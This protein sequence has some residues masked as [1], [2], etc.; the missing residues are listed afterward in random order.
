[1]IFPAA[2]ASQLSESQAAAWFV[3]LTFTGLIAILDFGISTL[4][5]KKISQESNT[6]DKKRFFNYL[7]L[8]TIMLGLI[9]FLLIMVNES[10]IFNLYSISQSNQTSHAFLLFSG[11]AVLFLSM[12][13]IEAYI[14]ALKFG[15]IISR[16]EIITAILR[17]L[18]LSYVWYEHEI[19]ILTL[20]LCYLAPCILTWIYLL[21]LYQRHRS[22]VDTTL[23]NKDYSLISDVTFSFNSWLITVVA[24]FNRQG[25]FLVAAMFVTTTDQI[26]LALVMLI[27][28]VAMQ[29]IST[30]INVLPPYTNDIISEFKG[31]GAKTLKKFVAYNNLIVT[32]VVT[33]YLLSANEVLIYIFG[34]SAPQSE[35]IFAVT[36]PIL[37][38]YAIFSPSNIARTI[39]VYANNIQL[40]LFTEVFFVTVYLISLVIS[41]SLFGGDL[42][43]I[44][45]VTSLYYLAKFFIGPRKKFQKIYNKKIDGKFTK[46]FFFTVLGAAY[47]LFG[48]DSLTTFVWKLV[49]VVLGATIFY[50]ELKELQS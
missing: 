24:Y 18:S 9:Y 38:C 45:V 37:I 44:S 7:F 25:F 42:I 31:I 2:A 41:F 8:T 13:V 32:F 12:R 34:Q 20:A 22:V 35:L 14:I 39:L 26:V 1:M 40:V 16:L 6:L 4:V 47:A 23:A 15:Y 11:Y 48:F 33:A 46:M 36:L 21:F 10:Y 28:S 5:I 27:I 30:P 29:L 3:I 49:I 17:V 50:R 43:T 19:N